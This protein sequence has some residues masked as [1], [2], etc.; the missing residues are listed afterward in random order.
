MKIIE[1]LPE[2]DVGGV[3]RHVIDLSNELARRRHEVLVI[4]AGGR[5]EAQ[6]SPDV[7][8]QH[9][10]VH[11]KN[12]FTILSCASKISELIKKEKYQIIHAHSRVPAWIAMYAA[13]KADIPFV[14]TAHSEFST[15]KPW[16]YKPYRQAGTTIC[17]TEA[18][19]E[20]MK[21]CFYD[22]T[23]VILNGLDTPKVTHKKPDS[24]KFLYV[25]R[26]SQVKGIQDCLR[27]LPPELDW[28]FDIVGIGPYEKELKKLAA[29]LGI[30]GRVFFRGFS[31]NPDK[32]M[33]NSSCLLFPS[34]EEGFGLVLARAAQIGLP[35]IVSDIPPFVELT[36]GKGLVPSENID[37]LRKAI[38]K[39]IKTGKT[40]ASIP[41]ENI[42]TIEKMTDA[43]ERIYDDLICE[44]R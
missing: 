12:P 17:V 30:A 23:Q 10:P 13:D 18:V 6:L 21:S 8:K 44:R 26:I 28:T 7:K 22:N 25:G 39:F 14:V 11:K 19:R 15:K 38:V 31:D 1:I 4:S 41:A 36:G 2:L 43:T 27:A 16:I 34:H 35:F 42:P 5:M 24:A 3:E 29:E 33:A 37:E 20:A 32:Y 40:E 9:L